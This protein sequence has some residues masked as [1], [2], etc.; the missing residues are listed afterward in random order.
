MSKDKFETKSNQLPQQL[1]YWYDV[2]DTK[3]NIK[4]T[5]CAFAI[6][7]GNNNSQSV[8][9]L[10]QYGEFSNT[11]CHN[12]PQYLFFPLNDDYESLISRKIS[13]LDIEGYNFI[14]Q[15]KD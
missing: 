13:S 6:N 2:F 1:V 10:S 11:Y 15:S 5:L 14:L 8:V 4:G 7:H 12:L 3:L 9:V